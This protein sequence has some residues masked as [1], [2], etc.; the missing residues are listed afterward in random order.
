MVIV[1]LSQVITA[2]DAE[3]ISLDKKS[4]EAKQV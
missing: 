2:K 4:K 1:L 3:F